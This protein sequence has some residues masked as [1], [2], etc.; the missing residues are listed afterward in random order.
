MPMKTVVYQ[1][2]RTT[3]VAPWISR[4][5]ETVRRWAA[6]RGF[7]YELVDDA[8]F[9]TVPTWFREKVGGHKVIMSDLARLHVG[10][11]LLQQYDRAVWVD[12]DVVVFDPDRLEIEAPAGYALCREGWLSRTPEGHLSWS[13]RAN[14]MALVLCRDNPFVDFYIHACESIVREARGPVGNLDVGTR[15]LTILSQAMP[16]PLLTSFTVLSPLLLAA[17][18]QGDEARLE[19]YMKKLGA[20]V[21]AANLCHSFRG[22]RVDG[23]LVDDALFEAV[24]ERLIETRGALLNRFVGERG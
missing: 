16:L 2:Y 21:R 18:R 13:S 14:N 20:P 24:T 7:A 1:S 15:F 22:Q 17:I 10:K 9:D 19:I 11:R 23:V 4:A 6:D 12:A 8:L 3:A 5:L